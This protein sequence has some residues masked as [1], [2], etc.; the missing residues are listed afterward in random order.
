MRPLAVGILLDRMPAEG[1]DHPAND[2]EVESHTE[3]EEPLG[4]VWPLRIEKRVNAILK[5]PP[6]PKDLG[7]EQQ[8]QE[9]NEEIREQAR[10]VLHLPTNHD[11]PFGICRMM[12]TV[13]EGGT[14]DHRE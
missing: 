8:W 12:Q 2:A 14:D 5:S 11:R 3:E 7:A 1:E 10:D 13:P 6:L 9:E 4:E